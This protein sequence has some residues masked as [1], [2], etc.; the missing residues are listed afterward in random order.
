MKNLLD[1]L[2][3]CWLILRSR[4]YVFAVEGKDHKCV[5]GGWVGPFR[6]KGA[7]DQMRNYSSGRRVAHRMAIRLC[8]VLDKMWNLTPPPPPTK[9]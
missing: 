7:S 5:Y 2:R 6:G 8:Q 1:K 4:K 3:V 9:N